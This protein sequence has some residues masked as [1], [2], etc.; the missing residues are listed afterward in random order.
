MFYEEF[1]MV[2]MEAGAFCG[3]SI[4]CKLQ[5]I[6]HDNFVISPIF[7]ESITN[8]FKTGDGPF[9]SGLELKGNQILC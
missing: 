5:K 7:C 9:I 8:Q 1:G 6:F 4:K 3:L 2:I